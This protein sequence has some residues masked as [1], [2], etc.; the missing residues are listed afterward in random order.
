MSLMAF[1]SQS[2][3]SCVT[4]LPKRA[5]N[6]MKGEVNR[7]LPA[8]TYGTLISPV[9]VVVPRRT[10]VDFHPDLFPDKR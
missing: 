2:T 10:Y 1:S 7:L 8:S 6:I 4:L 3:F 5:L 9:S